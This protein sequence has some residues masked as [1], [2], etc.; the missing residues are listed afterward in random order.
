MEN[1]NNDFNFYNAETDLNLQ[2]DNEINIHKQLRRGKKYQTVVQGLKF[3]NQEEAKEFLK[4][5][6]KKIGIG[7]CLK[8]ME[9]IDDQNEVFLFNGDYSEKIKEFLV[10]DYNKSEDFIKFHG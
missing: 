5:M 6:K 3:K 2:Y 4:S 7:G 8:K 1:N 10:K 9:D